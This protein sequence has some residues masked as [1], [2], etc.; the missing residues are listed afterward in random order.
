MIPETGE[1]TTVSD[2]QAAL[3]VRRPS[4]FITRALVVAIVAAAALLATNNW[5]FVVVPA[6][7]A[8]LFIDYVVCAARPWFLARIVVAAGV[9]VSAGLLLSVSPAWAFRE[10]F[11]IDPPSGIRDVR[12]HR[13]Y[14]G[15]P[16]EQ[17]LFIEFTA[18]AGAWQQLVD[19]HTPASQSTA[20]ERWRAAGGAW[21]Q[22]FDTFGG[23][24]VT[25]FSRASWA[26]IRPME[27]PEVYDLGESNHGR[28]VLLHEPETG[29]CIALHVRF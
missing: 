10:A 27:H 15:G 21:D 12:I 9:G 24:T 1:T 19:A 23:P 28:L 6:A 25:T 3:P 7:V 8:A 14:L 17:A 5:C 2:A 16:G 13:H 29:R 18:D 26:R 11:E 22:L 20:I 4:A